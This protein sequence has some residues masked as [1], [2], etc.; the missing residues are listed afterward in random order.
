MDGGEIFRP[1]SDNR[2]LR[3]DV[4]IISNYTLFIKQNYYFTLYTR[5]SGLIYDLLIA[6]TILTAVY[7]QAEV[8]F[9]I[10]YAT[11]GSDILRNEHKSKNVDIEN[12]LK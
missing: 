6:Y 1:I 10:I 2:G 5:F 12:I 8:V 4:K 7:N 11:W 3:G 9:S